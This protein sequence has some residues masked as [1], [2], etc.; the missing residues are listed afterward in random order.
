[1][2]S[3]LALALIL[4][5]GCATAPTERE[6]SD[7]KLLFTQACA[8]GTGAQLVKGSIWM[9]AISKDA[10]GQ[11]PATVTAKA[12]DTLLLEVTNLLGS[13]QAIITV[14]GR[15]YTVTVPDKAGNRTRREGAGSWGGIPLNWASDLF[16]GRIP[17]P[18]ETQIAGAR[19]SVNEE[20]QLIVDIERG[21]REK[22]VYSFRQWAGKAWPERLHW[23]K[24][25]KIAS[26]VE[27]KFD[28][29]EDRSASPRKWE[30]KSAL[31]EVKVRWRDRE[32]TP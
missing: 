30:A 1:V 12:P 24:H 5:S 20:R 22:F 11:F 26:A 8:P 15:K 21:E 2:R 9:K 32:A 14:E 18:T 10:S 3:K 4:V 25:G 19:L 29:P 13:T 16:L 17:C 7:P 28:D 27:F 23:E 31:G 6:A